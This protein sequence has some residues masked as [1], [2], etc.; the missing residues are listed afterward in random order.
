MITVLQAALTLTCRMADTAHDLAA[1]QALRHA[2]FIGGVGLDAD[3]F[4]AV[5]EHVM[6]EKGGALVCTLRLRVLPDG[7]D[8]TDSYTGSF[9]HFGPMRGPT[10][11]VGRFCVAENA[12]SPDVLRMAWVAITAWVDARD[13][14]HLFGCASFTDTDPAPYA[15][16]FGLLQSAHL[17][18]M[19]VVPQSIDNKSL[20][21]VCD[22]NFDRRRA[23]DQLPPLL[24]SYLGM[25]GY[26]SDHLIIDRSLGTL[27]VFTGLRIAD[28]PAARARS[29]RR[30]A[31]QTMGLHIPAPRNS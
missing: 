23:M 22:I 5:S 26:V 16:A 18:N 6:V 19:N 24:R 17:G 21:A 2:C 30:L 31:G 20:H 3:R 12:F 25:G 11:E 8:L 7:A 13:I 29:L 4:D 15:D 9:Y 10:L 28:I 27:H 14:Q 1:C